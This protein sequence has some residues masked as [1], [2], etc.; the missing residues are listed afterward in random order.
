VANT[1]IEEV[2]VEQ[3]FAKFEGLVAEWE[4]DFAEDDYLRLITK[5]YE[6][7]DEIRMKAG[8]TDD[9]L[10]ARE[11]A[12]LDAAEAKLALLEVTV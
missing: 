10:I 4:M 3:E 2:T 9:V 11:E 6:Y 5:I 8:Y 12:R 7:A 1:P